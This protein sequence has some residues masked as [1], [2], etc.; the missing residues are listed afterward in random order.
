MKLLTNKL[1]TLALVAVSA[2]SSCKQDPD[3]ITVNVPGGGNQT[4]NVTYV[5]SLADAAGVSASAGSLSGV[6]LRFFNPVTKRMTSGTSS[7]AD[8]NIV[9]SGMQP[10][11]FYGELTSTSY[12]NMAFTADISGNTGGDSTYVATSRLYLFRKDGTVTGKTY[13]NFGLNGTTPSPTVGIDV[14]ELDMKLGYELVTSGMNAFPMGSGPGRL[15]AV[16][17]MPQVVVTPQ[18]PGAA[19]GFTFDQVYVTESG[20]LNAYLSMVPKG[21]TNGLGGNNRQDSTFTLTTATSGTRN[22]LRVNVYSNQ[23]SNVGNLLARP[24]RM[25]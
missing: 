12:A 22:R 3:Q 19:G 10:G 17:L 11:S 14:A 6:N 1:A 25:P 7:D 9:I 16:K 21:F 8:G 23:T 20:M 24:D 13:G 18:T 5:I 15:T 4:A 2:L